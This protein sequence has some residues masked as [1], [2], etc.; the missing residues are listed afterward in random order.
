[1]EG[2]GHDKQASCNKMANNNE[3]HEAASSDSVSLLSSTSD[4]VIQHKIDIIRQFSLS[5]KG[6]NVVIVTTGKSGVGKSVL[7]WS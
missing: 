5:K 7:S 1:M 4:S 2:T 3:E 6:K